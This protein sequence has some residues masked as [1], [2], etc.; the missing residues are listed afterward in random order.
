MGIEVK[1]IHKQSFVSKK[2]TE[3]ILLPE[4]RAEF[5]DISRQNQIVAIFLVDNFGSKGEGTTHK[6]YL[7]QSL[8]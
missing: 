3:N 2:A 4:T 6:P 8:K 1:L 7:K 5:E